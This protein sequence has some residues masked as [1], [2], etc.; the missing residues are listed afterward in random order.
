[1]D[2]W[3]AIRARRNVRTFTDQ[4]IADNDLQRILEAGRRSPSSNNDQ[5]WAFVVCLE[6]GQL[7]QLSQAWQYGAHIAGSAAT[8]VLLGPDV[9]SAVLRESIQYDLGQVTMSMMLA[10]ADMGIGSSHSYIG[11]QELVRDLLKFP[12]DWFAAIMISLGY[13]ADRPLTPISNPRRRRLL[14]VVHVGGW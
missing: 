8:V 14:E 5:R 10:A 12:A 11:D 9:G 1:M 7:E 3:D 6:R 13:P 2:T 4:T